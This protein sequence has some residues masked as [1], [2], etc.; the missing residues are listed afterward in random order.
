MR[1]EKIVSARSHRPEGAGVCCDDG[2]CNI[3]YFHV[4]VPDGKEIVN[5]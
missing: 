4:L 1:T 5:P 3:A 2:G